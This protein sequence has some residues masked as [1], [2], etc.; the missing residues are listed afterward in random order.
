MRILVLATGV[1]AGI[2]GLAIIA[3]LPLTAVHRWLIAAGWAVLLA[4]ELRQLIRAW[5]AVAELVVMPDRRVAC[6]LAQAGDRRR[7]EVR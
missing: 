1:V 3:S 5:R 6:R 4:F 7:S 2:G